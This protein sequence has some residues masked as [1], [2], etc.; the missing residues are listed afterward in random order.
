[1]HVKDI[2]NTYHTRVYAVR[3][4]SLIWNDCTAKNQ[5]QLGY[6]SDQVRN[7]QH[8][9]SVKQQMGDNNEQE[10]QCQHPFGFWLFQNHR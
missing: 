8:K 1:M 6:E 4:G 2:I 10:K 5:H 9:V 7:Q 3:V